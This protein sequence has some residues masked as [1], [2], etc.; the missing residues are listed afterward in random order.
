MTH[1]KLS[2]GQVS[3]Y[4]YTLQQ[5]KREHSNVSFPQGWQENEELLAGFGVYKIHHEEDPVFD[6][7]TQ[8]IDVAENPV[9][10]DGK[11]TITRTAVDLTADELAQKLADEISV[12]TQFYRTE[13][14]KMLADSD[15]TQLPD[16][17]LT[18]AKKA[19]WATYR[20]ALRDITDQAGF[21]LDITVPVPPA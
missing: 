20:Q 21:P 14:N 6:E 12:K 5:F 16:S 18:D 1:I 17:P 9:L 11:W 2:N 19:E 7:A 13:R 10:K 4:N 8:R 3:D 15:W